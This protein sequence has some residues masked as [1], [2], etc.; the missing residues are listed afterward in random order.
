MRYRVF[1]FLSGTDHIFVVK[2]VDFQTIELAKTI[3]PSLQTVRR[4]EL[5]LTL[6]GQSEDPLLGLCDEL[7]QISGQNKLESI[8]IS[9]KMENECKMGDECGRLERVLL[10]SGWPMLKYVSLDVTINSLSIGI[11]TSFGMALNSLPQTQLAGLMESKDLDFRYSLREHP[12]S[13][14]SE[15]M[16]TAEDMEMA[17]Y[18]EMGD[19]FLD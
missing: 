9:I 4:I 17:E 19:P 15:A 18:V 8:E 16:E 14:A 3:A 11:H 6:Y 12:M 5:T 2:H 1:Y 13:W 10:T 7:E